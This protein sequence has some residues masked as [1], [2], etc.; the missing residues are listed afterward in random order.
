MQKQLAR[1]LLPAA[2]IERAA[3]CLC[4]AAP[5]RLVVWASAPVAVVVGAALVGAGAAT[6]TGRN[7]VVTS[8]GSAVSVD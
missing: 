5:K 1:A 8:A 3:K 6:T 2:S 7:G 4:R